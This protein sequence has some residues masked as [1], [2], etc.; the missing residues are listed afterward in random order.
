[1]LWTLIVAAVSLLTAT[2]PAE[3]GFS[4]EL[5]DIVPEGPNFRW[6]YQIIFETLPGRERLESGGGVLNPGVAGSQDFLTMY[7]VNGG[8]ILF[9]Y[10]V[11][12]GPEF[13][14][15]VQ[16]VGIDPLGLLPVDGATSTNLIL[17]YQGPPVVES[18]VFGGLSIVAPANT[19]KISQYAS[20]RTDNFGLSTNRKI[21][22]I[23]PIELPIEYFVPEPRAWLLLMLACL[24]AVVVRLS[25]IRH[26]RGLTMDRRT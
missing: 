5:I 26:P 17:R 1:L 23:G 16:A 9:E 13:S 25:C 3:A 2:R 12:T 8:W 15:Q 7:D 14:A 6:N 18:T 22:E 4:V 19:S 20:Q 21:A 11:T 24:G 10:S